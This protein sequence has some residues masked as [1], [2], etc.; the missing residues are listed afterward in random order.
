MN[1]T[2]NTNETEHKSHTTEIEKMRH[3]FSHVLAQA[4]TRLYPDAKLGIGP[5]VEDGF[6]YEFD[7]PEKLDE[8][9]LPKIEKEMKKIIEEEL[10]I[11]QLVLPRDQAFDMLHQQGQIYKTELLQEVPD[12]EI[13]F[14]RTGDEFID[15]CRGPHVSHTGKLKIF[16]LTKLE[17]VHWKGD[18]NRPEMYRISGIAFETEKEMEEYLKWEE[19]KEEKE[20]KVL[21]PKR[22]YFNFRN[23]TTG[24]GLPIWMQEGT[25]VIN[26]I[27]QK[28]KEL[29][30]QN[31]FVEVSTPVISKVDL[32]KE[33]GHF[34]FYQNEDINPFKISGEL[35]M[36]RPMATPSHIEVY[37][38]KRHSNNTLPYRVFEMAKLY[39]EEGSKELNGIART[40]EFTQDIAHIFID[41][42][43]TVEEI[44]KLI[45]FNISTLK[46]FG[47]KDYRLQFAR[48]DKR[49][50]SD[51][52][53]NE[54]T[55][56]TSETILI[57][58]LEGAKLAAREAVGEADFCGPK[59]DFFI[60]DING[61][62]WQVSSIQIDLVTPQ[63]TN[64]VF[65]NKKGHDEMPYL[66]HHSAIGSLER[67]FAL[68]IEYYAG[69][70]PLWL[71]PTQVRVLPVSEKFVKYARYVNR[72]LAAKG[73]RVELD[74][75]DESLDTRIR[76]AQS[77]EIPYMVVLGK[78]EESSNVISIRPRTGEEMGIMRI[79]EFVDQLKSNL[80][81]F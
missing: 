21:G 76:D 42:K 4:V 18:P 22:D 16:K 48:R 79:E 54:D 27:S 60:K 17:K 50:M 32:F 12:E 14:Y 69:A 23:N 61:R 36:L 65:R 35:Y 44:V 20:H 26:V 52:L 8:K 25:K 11:T 47:F 13:S 70:L 58:A 9:A 80:S 10:P 68:L 67:F 71:A 28:V 55:W 24:P 59:I 63:R 38:S 49:K 15:L 51:Y 81:A 64:I 74:D 30:E 45:E 1:D 57:K 34:E 19:E 6:Y 73:L 31:G 40:R 77:Q 46:L 37:R 5:A 2:T 3:S 53:G 41:R 29:R 43:D 33:T 56:K 75:R 78:Q 7:I 39:R 62:E 66:I 72:E